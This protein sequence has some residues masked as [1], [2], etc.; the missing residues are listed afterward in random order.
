MRDLV[1]VV[2]RRCTI[3]LIGIASYGLCLT[4]P[5]RA[6]VSPDTSFRIGRLAGLAGPSLQLNERDRVVAMAPAPKRWDSV[7]HQLVCRRH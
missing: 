7:Q 1:R 4:A 3:V 6:A 5:A 2:I